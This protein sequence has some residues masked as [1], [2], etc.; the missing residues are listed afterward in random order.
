M[1]WSYVQ[2]RYRPSDRAIVRD[3]FLYAAPESSSLRM[4]SVYPHASDSG[5]FLTAFSVADGINAK[6]SSRY[7]EFPGSTSEDRLYDVEG[8]LIALSICSLADAPLPADA[9]FL[10]YSIVDAV[11]AET[12]RVIG[13]KDPNF[14]SAWSRVIIDS[15]AG[16]RKISNVG[17]LT[18]VGGSP[19]LHTTGVVLG[20]G[21]AYDRIVYCPADAS[22]GTL[23]Q[24]VTF[25]SGGT[26]AARSFAWKGK[27]FLP[28]VVQ[29]QLDGGPTNVHGA[30]FWLA[31][32]NGFEPWICPL[33]GAWSVSRYATFSRFEAPPLNPPIAAT[34]DGDEAF[35]FASPSLSNVYQTQIDRIVVTPMDATL[36]LPPTQAQGLAYLAGG[37]TSVFDGERVFEA[38]FL[39]RPILTREE[40]ST[41]GVGL[42]AGTYLYIAEWEHFDAKGNRHTSAPSP[43]LSVEIV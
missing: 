21:A 12:T 5:L 2:A 40:S 41:E 22:N 10:S 43:V 35:V 26:P 15:T 24:G 36:P 25:V 9:T 4:F 13:F 11:P 38:G 7:P 16:W 30:L 19:R 6:I 27:A 18:D 39:A 17:T 20:S 29:E 23:V 31:E 3:S 32:T 37:L 34:V 14:A 1:S 33:V 28:V 42:A 8:T